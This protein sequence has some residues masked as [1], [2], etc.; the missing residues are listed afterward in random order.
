MHLYPS[1]SSKR[2]N[3]TLQITP[4][5]DIQWNV[6]AQYSHTMPEQR[7]FGASTN[8]GRERERER[9]NV[10]RR[11]KQTSRYGKLF[12]L[13]WWEGLPSLP[14]YHIADWNSCF[15]F[16]NE[17]RGKKEFSGV[18]T[19]CTCPL[20]LLCRVISMRSFMRCYCLYL[21][22]LLGNYSLFYFLYSWYLVMAELM[23]CLCSFLVIVSIFLTFV[24]SI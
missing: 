14:S 10:R 22:N 12:I 19:S 18:Y 17:S 7:Q 5:K 4:I 3:A 21:M 20:N 24:N 9:L 6:P 16:Q 11:L 1:V 15:L 2:L 13:F 23:G 8:T